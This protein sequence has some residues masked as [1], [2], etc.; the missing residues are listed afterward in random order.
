MTEDD[1]MEIILSETN[2]P[3]RA[4]L[5]MYLFDKVI[6]HCKLNCYIERN[7]LII[8]N[9][10]Y[11]RSTVIQCQTIKKSL[12]NPSD[13]LV[14]YYIHDLKPAT[15][16]STIKLEDMGDPEEMLRVWKETICLVRSLRKTP[17]SCPSLF[18]K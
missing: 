4:T 13:R 12:N 10:P 1:L 7:D 17:E 5:L 8:H 9:H 6:Y 11:S 16:L 3:Y 2:D 14:L 18:G 15:K